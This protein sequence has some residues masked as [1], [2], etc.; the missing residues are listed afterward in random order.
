MK[1][2]ALWGNKPNKL[3]S[4]SSA[5][6]SKHKQRSHKSQEKK[7]TTWL[8]PIASWKPQTR[9][10]INYAIM[11]GSV[12]LCLMMSPTRMPGMELLGIAPNWLLIWVVAWS[13]K[14]SAWQGAIDD[15]S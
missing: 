13:V 5:R 9:A 14:R 7:S 15:F 1:M 2:I 12:L 10:T 11:F 6:K 3:K 4:Q 8:K